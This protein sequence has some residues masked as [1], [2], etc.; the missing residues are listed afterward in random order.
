MHFGFLH[1][2]T[3]YRLKVQ[4]QMCETSLEHLCCHQE[5]FLFIEVILGKGKQEGQTAVWL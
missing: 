4:S 3:L 5:H 2:G 1:N